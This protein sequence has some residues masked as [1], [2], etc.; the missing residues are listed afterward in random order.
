MNMLLI[1][2]YNVIARGMAKNPKQ[3]MGSDDARCA[4]RE[5][6]VQCVKRYVAGKTGM[7]ARIY[8]DGTVARGA[9]ELS[10]R[11]VRV[12]FTAGDQGADN[13]IIKFCRAYSKP[14]DIEVVSDDWGTLV[15]HIRSQVGKVLSVAEF[16]RRL[17]SGRRSS[18][19][20][21]VSAKVKEEQEPPLSQSDR[22]AINQTLPD[23]W[24]R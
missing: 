16:M 9:P 13:A 15:F 17:D 1:D 8:F 10:D 5:E 19:A 23:K 14:K 22:Q 18:Q 11:Q 4:L 12:V 6:L 24:F 3:A 20:S 7:E 2:G 21:R